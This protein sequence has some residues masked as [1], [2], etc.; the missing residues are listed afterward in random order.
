[1][2]SQ[3][4]N[5]AALTNKGV[6]FDFNYNRALHWLPDDRLSVD[7]KWTD[8]IN[9]TLQTDPSTAPADFAGTFGRGFSR[10]FCIPAQFLQVWH[11]HVRLADGLSQWR[12]V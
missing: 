9:N 10:D 3:L 8:L 11:R 4:I 7:L 5:V 12:P 1:M 2:N 6:D